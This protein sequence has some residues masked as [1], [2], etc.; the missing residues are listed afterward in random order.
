MSNLKGK[1]CT[2][3]IIIVVISIGLLS[4]YLFYLNNILEMNRMKID[5][6]YS[7]VNDLILQNKR[8]DLVLQGILTNVTLVKSKLTA[9]IVGL[10]TT[11]VILSFSIFFYKGL[12]IYSKVIFF[13]ASVLFFLFFRIG[14]VF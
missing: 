7:R 4:A 6:L 13:I 5:N 1:L 10:K 8:V 3:S 14:P 11:G 12:S 2:V 9:L